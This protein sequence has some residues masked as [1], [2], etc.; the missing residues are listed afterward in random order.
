MYTLAPS[1]TWQN[2]GADSGDLAAA[3][4]TLGIPHP[5]GYPLFTLL[6][7]IFAHLPTIEPARGVGI[8]AALAGAAAVFMLTC[9]GYALIAS[10]GENR[11]A[12]LV[13]PLAAMGFAF[14]PALWSQATI[15]EVYTLN[16]L[17]VS[18]ILWAMISDNG[19]R[20]AIAA[21]AFGFGMTHHLSILLFAPGAWWA[22]KP[23]RRDL[24]SVLLLGAPLLLYIYLPIRAAYY[25]AVN[26]G[27]PSTLDGFWWVVTAAPYRAYLFGLPLTDILGH[28]AFAARLLFQQF[29]PPGVALAL[30]GFFRLMQFRARLA[31]A[32][33]LSTALVVG[34]SIIYAT[35]DSFIYLLPA[36]AIALLWLVYG[37][38]DLVSLLE[39]TP[40]SKARRG[41][42]SGPRAGA[43]NALGLGARRAGSWLVVIGLAGL[44]VY[45]VLAN[46]G[47][48]DLAADR[49]ALDYAK[50]IIQNAPRDAV[51]FADGDESLFALVY[52]RQAIAFNDSGAV[53]VSQGL[54][55]YDWYYDELGKM[56]NEV[57]FAP[58]EVKSDYHQRAVEIANV[59]FAEGRAVCFT[60]SSPLLQ[61]FDYDTRYGLSCIVAEKQ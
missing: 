20:V 13:P 27:D 61:E 15:A 47:T 49:K 14:A 6:S 45:N 16:L 34:Y 55:Q 42:T 12:G 8:L 58:P 44:V 57:Q 40:Q 36:F 4:F 39:P 59:T 28:A 35:R 50:N 54:L 30:W 26:W 31:G 18:I 23:G 29:T 53:I 22:L 48:M 9:A 2:E 3:A 38:A 43:G 1:V 11:F 51:I 60:K 24:R 25:P 5:P 7:S 56:M 17:F 52:Y 46:F 21:A 10:L 37:A 19:H 41:Q 33:G 32:M